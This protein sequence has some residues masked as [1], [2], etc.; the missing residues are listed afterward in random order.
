MEDLMTRLRF[1]AA[2]DIQTLKGYARVG[3]R[4]ERLSPITV[5][6]GFTFQKQIPLDKNGNIK[7]ECKAHVTLPA[8][9]IEY[10]TENQGSMMG[11]GDFQVDLEEVNL[12][13]D[14]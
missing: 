2:L 3:F 9:E 12:F 6:D 10:S 4:T 1:R 5:M 13:L 14:Y 11:M 8:P 7:V